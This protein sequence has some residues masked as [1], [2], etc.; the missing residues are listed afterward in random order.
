MHM[1]L[2]SELNS[3]LFV[4]SLS[5]C[6]G[7]EALLIITLKTAAEKLKGESAYPTP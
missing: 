3:P 4:I 6:L 2:K 1:W 5:I 7:L